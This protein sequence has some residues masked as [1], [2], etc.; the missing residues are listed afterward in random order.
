MTSVVE[1]ISSS[2]D[3]DRVLE[4]EEAS[5]VNPT[6][7]EWYESE[8]QRPDVCFIFALRTAEH[9]VAAFCAFW[10]VVD[11]IHINNLAVRPELR[12]RGLGAASPGRRARRSG[13]AWR[14]ARDTRSPPLECRG[15]ALV[16]T[17]RIRA[18]RRAYQLLHEPYRGRLDPVAVGW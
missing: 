3:L 7:R 4:I 2:S 10:K 12:G 14:A 15:A 5:F 1:R 13:K 11:Q 8:L 9:P 16:R 17:R 6:T 18:R